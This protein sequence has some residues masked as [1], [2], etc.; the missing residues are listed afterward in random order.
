L[1]YF[2]FTSTN[3]ELRDQ[4]YENFLQIYHQTLTEF[5][6]RLGSDGAKLFPFKA[7]KSQMRKF[8]R[9]GLVMATF[10][11]QML[12]VPKHDLPD[13]DQIAKDMAENKIDLDN[14]AMIQVG[15]DTSASAYKK[16]MNGVVR[17]IIRLGYY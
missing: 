13:M 15:D 5:V 9:Y 8:G 7:F 10:L 16:R 14:M 6:D 11:I 4:H 1:A 3:E 17:D 2:I 12:V